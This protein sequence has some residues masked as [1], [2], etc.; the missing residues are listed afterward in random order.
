M[1]SGLSD[2]LNAATVSVSNDTL[3]I[4]DQS[5]ERAVLLFDALS[6]KPLNDGKP[7]V[8]RLEV[9][10]VRTLDMSLSWH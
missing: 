1:D 2:T 3:A 8:H 4:R 6:G 10:E 7:L 9:S 5:D